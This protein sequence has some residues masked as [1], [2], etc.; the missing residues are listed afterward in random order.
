MASIIRKHPNLV[1]APFH[2]RLGAFVVDFLVTIIIGI[3][4][5]MS[6]D[7]IFYRTPAGVEASH[8]LFSVREAS[9][10]YVTNSDY[11]L[12]FLKDED[13]SVDER[14]V[15][16]LESLRYFYLDAKNPFDHT[17]LYSYEN[18]SYYDENLAF[19]F[20]V[21]VL[22]K[23]KDHTLFTF[24]EE[25]G[26]VTSF[27]F[28]PLVSAEAKNE[29][30]IRLYNWAIKDLESSEAFL[31]ARKPHTNVLFYGGGA[32]IALGALMPLLVMPLILKHG[33]SIGKYVFGIALT[34]K[35]GYEVSWQKVLIRYLVLAIIELGA[36][37][38]LYGIPLFLA[39]ASVTVTRG[40][41]ALHDLLAGTLVVDA[42]LS[43]IFGSA[44]DEEAYYRPDIS[45]KDKSQ[46]SFY[47]MPTKS[48]K[49]RKTFA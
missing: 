37:I 45:S 44:K 42:R 3:L 28:K 4:A 21:M 48:T 19:D 39:S 30:W 18:S 16:Y 33:Q 15:A 26:S 38:R 7:A 6:I 25:E 13:I 8:Q 14:E 47:Q 32:A 35:D 27:A 12:T 10:L 11:Q 20:Y 34:N 31:Y 46:I 29:E 23:G 9:Q 2:K 24:V 36:S 41:R 40:S 22:N 43:K 5:Y 1:P 49:T 17:A